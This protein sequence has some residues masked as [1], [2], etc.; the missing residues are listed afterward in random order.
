VGYVLGVDIGTTYSAAATCENGRGEIAHLGDRSPAIPSVV[1]LRSDGEVLVGEAAERRGSHEPQRLAREFKRR[2]GDPVPLVLGGTPYGVE[3]LIAHLLAGIYRRVIAEQGGAPDITVV[4]HPASWGAFKLDLLSQAVRQADIT[5]PRFIS[6]PEAAAIYYAHRQRLATGEVVA[7]YDFGG[8]TFDASVLRKTS[9]GWESLGQPEGMDRLGGIDFDQAVFR[10][11]RQQVPMDNLDPD[12]PTTIAAL[13]QLRQQCREAKEALSSDTEAIIHVMLPGRNADVHLMRDDFEQ[14]IRPRV[15]ES[16]AAME[17]AVRSA[18]LPMDAIDKV[19]LVGGSS[20]IPIIGR[21]IEAATGRPV[22]VDASP[23]YAI[24]LGAAFSGDQSLTPAASDLARPAPQEEPRDSVSAFALSVPAPPPLA[25]PTIV[26]APPDPPAP[27]PAPSEAPVPPR[28]PP[29]VMAQTN[30]APTPNANSD[31]AR[32]AA[33]GILERD[34]EDPVSREAPD[35]AWK[36]P[37]VRRRFSRLMIGG[38]AAAVAIAIIVAVIVSSGG[39]GEPS[40]AA[41]T[42]VSVAPVA[43]P[44][45]STAPEVAITALRVEGGNYVI[46]FGTNFTAKIDD[47]SKWHVHFFFDTV[48]VVDAGAPGAGP[49]YL[50]D[51]PSPFRGVKVSDRPARATQICVLPATSDHRIVPSG[52]GNCWALP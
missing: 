19:L 49:W 46:S 14:M 47:P 21:T 29:T 30:D 7:V 16:I 40:G 20:R 6:E 42:T 32:P 43:Q 18:G 33:G 2:L 22:A 44:G 17:R 36:A 1:L 28:A 10:Y 13:T 51:A 31:A 37:T 25:P 27:T 34:A 39:D 50:Y 52:V 9:S 45:G 23:K 15:L 11:V 8:G 26:T 41:G 24:A 38:L 3:A 48:D 4:S 12:D 35:V 5:S